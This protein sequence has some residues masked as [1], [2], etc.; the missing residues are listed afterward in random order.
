MQD[1]KREA[2]D[3]VIESK[4]APFTEVAQAE[5]IKWESAPLLGN[6]R[7]VFFACR[8]AWLKDTNEKPN[9]DRETYN[10]SSIE[11]IDVVPYLVTMGYKH[12]KKRIHES[13]RQ[14]LLIKMLRTRYNV[15][16][17]SEEP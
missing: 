16:P 8:I 3:M 17:P 6:D 1:S 4:S 12:E 5:G 11:P 9:C 2:D 15:P 14:T 7:K 10:T 13:L